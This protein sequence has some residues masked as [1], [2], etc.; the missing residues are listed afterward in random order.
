[1]YL[2][3]KISNRNCNLFEPRNL[4]AFLAIMETLGS[5]AYVSFLGC[6]NKLSRTGWLKT[7]GSYPLP[8]A[9]GENLFLV[10]PLASGGCWPSRTWPG[11]WQQ[12]SNPSLCL[13]MAIIPLSASESNFHSSPTDT[14]RI[15]QG[16][17]TV[18]S[19]RRGL[20]PDL[21]TSAETLFQ[22]SPHSQV[23]NSPG[24][25]WGGTLVNPGLRL[26][27]KGNC[28]VNPQGKLV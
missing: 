8:A 22:I 4:V 10:S 11:L 25:G 2:R 9:Q 13:H 27:G 3:D 23:P 7:I 12:N 24:I 15:R 20:H 6:S 26:F 21:A 16:P 17:V 28:I 18:H 14:S 5:S 1:M 19:N